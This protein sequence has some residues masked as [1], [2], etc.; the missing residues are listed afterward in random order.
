VAYDRSGRYLARGHGGAS[1]VSVHELPS[2]T[3]VAELDFAGGASLLAL[4]PGAELIAAVGEEGELEL[5]DRGGTLLLRGESVLSGARHYEFWGARLDFTDDGEGVVLRRRD[6]C[7]RWSLV[8]PDAGRCR[9]FEPAASLP[10][11]WQLASGAGLVSVF[12]HDRG[13]R[14]TLPHAGPW[15]A[16]PRQPMLLACSGGLFEL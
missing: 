16:N 10:P 2:T 9:A 1:T 15:V 13:D 4:T 5:R 7:R 11:G 12:V 14:L 8:G 6:G 3:R